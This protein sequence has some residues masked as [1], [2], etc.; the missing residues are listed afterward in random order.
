ML[1]ASLLAPCVW[2]AVPLVYNQYLTSSYA[3]TGWTV[4][5]A[6]DLASRSFAGVM[7]DEN[8]NSGNPL[9]STGYYV[10]KQSDGN[11]SLV[12]DDLDKDVPIQLDVYFNV[13]TG[14][15]LEEIAGAFYSNYKGRL[16]AKQVNDDGTISGSEANDYIIYSNAK[17]LT[18][19][20]S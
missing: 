10:T 14:S 3:D 13:L 7:A 20:V 16:I 15:A 8:V 11:Y 1:L 5:S 17:I 18:S 2:A 9:P 4:A 19:L 6:D 12:L